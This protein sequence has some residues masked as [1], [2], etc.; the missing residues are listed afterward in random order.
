MPS[1]TRPPLN[2]DHG[3]A[4]TETARVTVGSTVSIE[5]AGQVETWTIGWDGQ[6]NIDRGVIG[7]HTPLA[8]ALLGAA[9]GETREYIV[10]GRR[11]QVTCLSV[12]GTNQ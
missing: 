4:R 6:S 2:A 9:A 10:G 8:R 3:A 5:C 12:T 7:A 1:R 11:W